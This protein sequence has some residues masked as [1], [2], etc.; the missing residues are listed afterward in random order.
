MVPA[1]LEEL[2]AI[3]M[4]LS[5]KADH[6]KLPKPQVPRFSAGARLRPAE[7]RERAHPLG[8]ARGSAAGGARVDRAPFLRRPRRELAA[9]GALL[10]HHPQESGHVERVDARHLHQPDHRAARRAI[11]MRRSRVLSRPSAN[12]STFPRTCPTTPAARCSLRSTRPMRCSAFGCSISAT[13]GRSRRTARSRSTPAASCSP[14]D[15][16]SR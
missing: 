1:Y 6:K 3:P 7:D 8:G 12:R 14:P 10:R 9:D 15:R 16:S 13:I 5:N 11:S 4:T 2:P